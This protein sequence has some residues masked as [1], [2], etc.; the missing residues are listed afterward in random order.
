MSDLVQQQE[1][2]SDIVESL[3]LD[4][5]LGR[6][7]PG[8]RVAYYVH[9]C[10]ILGI[11]PG[12]QPF[13]LIRLNGKLALYATKTCAN[14]LTR[15][16]R[17]SVEIKSTKIEGS[18]VIVEA[19]ATG[20]DQRFADDIG[21][22]DL[23]EEKLSKSN[24]LMKCATK[25]KR[26]A[27]LALVGLGVLDETEAVDIRGAQRVR[28]DVATGELEAEP[29]VVDTVAVVRPPSRKFRTS[30]DEPVAAG[31][32]AQQAP[33]DIGP[34]CTGKASGLAV[35]ITRRLGELA[36]H[37]ATDFGTAWRGALLRAGVD[38]S[39]YAA[40]DLRKYGPN[41]L[42]VQ[43]GLRVRE[44]LI[45]KLGPEAEE[46]DQELINDDLNDVDAVNLTDGTGT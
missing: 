13:Q 44:W 31:S 25:A 17:L 12:E 35:S 29:N 6:M 14:A 33:A 7:S 23:T 20:P 26:R 46:A 9:R 34:R 27:V 32:I 16:N 15:V 19:R 28:L 21:V 37:F 38:Q 10:R 41:A 36:E 1:L 30:D 5:D 3:V 2:S 39:K 4:G 11:D 42:T 22:L 8:Q 40:G 43:D 24:A 45:E 18:L